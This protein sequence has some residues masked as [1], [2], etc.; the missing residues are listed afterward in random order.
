[1]CGICGYISKNRILDESLSLMNNTM[2]HRGPDDDGILQM[3]LGEYTVGIAHRR[4]SILDL[5]SAGHQPMVDE[6]GRFALVYNGEIYN[7]LDIRRNLKKMGVR[8]KSTCDTETL[9]WALIKYGKSI[10]NELDGMYAF[11]FVDLVDEKVLLARDK[12][13]EKPLYYYWDEKELIFGSELKALMAHH[14][15]KKEIR[16][17]IIEQYFVQNS[18]MAPETIFKNTYKL[19]VGEYVEWNKG[20]LESFQYYNIVH[21]YIKGRDNLVWDYEE[22]K[23]TLKDIIYQSVSDR[24]VSD[25]P[26]GCFLSGG[27]DSTLVSA[28]ANEVKE[29]GIDTFC[30]GFDDEKINEAT[31]AKACAKAIGTKHHELIMNENDLLGEMSNLVK[32]YDEPFADMS[33]LATMLVAR[34]A[35]N[36][37]SVAL[38]GDGGDEYFAGYEKND[39]LAMIAR[40]RKL[41]APAR[42]IPNMWIIKGLESFQCAKYQVLLFEDSDN[43]VIQGEEYVRYSNVVKMILRQVDGRYYYFDI[44]DLNKIVNLG[45]KRNVLDMIRYLPEEVLSKTDRA[46]MKYSLEMR[47]PLLSKLV[48]EYSFHIPYE[49]KYYQCDKKHILKDIL[50]EYISYDLFDRPKMGFGVPIR[51]WLNTVL[52][53]RLILYSD[54]EIIK[55]QGIFDSEGIKW[56]IRMTMKKANYRYYSTLWCFFVFQ[57]WY[58]MYIEDLWS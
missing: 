14:S 24:L 35:K 22:C 1:M 8:F 2:I 43:R 37:V 52:H 38:S 6:S 49:Y 30:I 3:D 26:V 4:L 23:K 46:S 53:D 25:V 36:Y 45:E 31:Y 40:G 39:T 44:P 15:F 10:L 42:Y 41:L 56:L 34:F 21:E 57:M 20:T 13:G 54:D 5:S 9:L 33:Q 58:Q 32:Y 28:I 50:K 12:T 7:H 27:I 29:G 19:S 47:T 51:R 48:T 16:T 18:I 11:A 17:D 55:R